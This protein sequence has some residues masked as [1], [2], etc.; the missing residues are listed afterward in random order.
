MMLY[1]NE[2]VRH[3]DLWFV[4]EQQILR[5]SYRYELLLSKL[6]SCINY[7]INDTFPLLEYHF[8]GGGQ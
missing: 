6:F 8:V 1:V 3:V 4:W 5:P 2:V 7:E